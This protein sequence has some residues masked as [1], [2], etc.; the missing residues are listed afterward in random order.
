MHDR[1]LYQQIL[2]ISSPWKVS[3]VVLDHGLK[4][5]LVKVDHSGETK[6]CC[7]KCGKPS[8]IHDHR[9]RQWR[10]LDTCQFQ[11]ILE[12]D[13]PR[14]DC[15]EH[16]VHQIDVPWAEPRSGFTALFEALVIDWLLT[17]ENRDGVAQLLGLSWDEVNGIMARS[18]TRGMARREEQPLPHLAVDET[19]FQK[20]HEYVT[21]ISDRIGGTVLDVLQDGKKETF[22]DWLKGLTKR[23]LGAIETVSMDMWKGFINA[24]LEVVPGADGKICF[25]RFHISKYLVDGVDK[26]RKQEHAKLMAEAG[27]SVLARTKFDWGRTSANIDNRSRRAFMALTR[28]TLKTARAWAMKE[29]AAGLWNYSSRTWAEK[30]WKQLIGWLERSRLGPMIKVGKMIKTHL[31][32]ILNAIEHQASN[33]KAEGINSG[34]QRIKSIARGFRNRENFRVAILF[35]FGGLDL[36]PATVA[37]DFS[38]RAAHTKPG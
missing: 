18:V 35:Y 14:V 7:P 22:A 1:A 32:G 2:G 37:R 19:S 29:T 23:T 15:A 4:R 6:P 10:H 20:R 33:G 36:Y 21:V 13:L 11:T 27:A 34:I 24:V 17:A 8:P 16:G 3:D 28:L 31:W 25:D 26:V 30:A 5:V 12:A 38:R 9:K